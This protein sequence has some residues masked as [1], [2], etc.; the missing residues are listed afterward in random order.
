MGLAT[1]VLD[2]MGC[3]EPTDTSKNV[4]LCPDNKCCFNG[5]EHFIVTLFAYVDPARDGGARD[6]DG[7]K[8]GRVTFKGFTDKQSNISD[9]CFSA[10]GE[11]VPYSSENAPV[12]WAAWDT[13]AADRRCE[14]RLVD[15]DVSPPGEWWITRPN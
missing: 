7:K 12:G 10:G 4:R 14:V 13:P 15:H 3:V 6:S 5:S 2:A 9:T 11:C 8:N 1:I